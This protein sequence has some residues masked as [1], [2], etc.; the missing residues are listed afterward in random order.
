MELLIGNND[1][2]QEPRMRITITFLHYW[3]ILLND[4]I[5][6]VCG[7]GKRRRHKNGRQQSFDGLGPLLSSLPV[8]GDMTKTL[9]NNKPVRVI[10]CVSQ[11]DILVFGDFFLMRTDG[12]KD[13]R[14]YGHTVEYCLFVTRFNVIFDLMTWSVW[15]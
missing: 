4:M 2:R 9:G 15:S 12:H 8:T 6:G 11:A 13:T 5:P 14:I 1:C 7:A 3:H 10:R